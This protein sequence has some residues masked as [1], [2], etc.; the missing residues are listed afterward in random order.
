MKRALVVIGVILIVAAFAFAR[1]C[2]PKNMP[3]NRA[4]ACQTITAAMTQ[5]PYV[6]AGPG[7][8]DTCL[9][10]RTKGLILSKGGA[11]GYQGLGI[12]PNVLSPGSPALGIAFKIQ[13]GDPTGR[14]RPA[15]A[16]NILWQLGALSFD[17]L[18][19]LSAF[20]PTLTLYNRRQLAIGESRPCF[21]LNKE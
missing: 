13:D 11:E 10:E 20:G 16:L 3:T 1:L 15:V 2:D 18:E 14:A 5:F 6:V 21:Q 4:A 19:A 9:M 7:R 17:D 8:F 12:F